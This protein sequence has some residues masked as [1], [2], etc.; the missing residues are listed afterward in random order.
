MKRV[1][2]AEWLQTALKVLSD[3]GVEGLKVERIA[4]R[5][6]ISKSGF[7]WHFQD[8]EDLRNQIIEYWAHEY[9]EVV[10]RNPEFLKGSPRD[11]LKR[12]M[13]MIVDADLTRYDLDMKAWSRTDPK[14]ARRVRQVFRVRFDFSREIFRAMGFRGEELEIRTRMFIGYHAWERLTFDS[15]SKTALKKWIPAKI[16]LLTSK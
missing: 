9:T 13:E 6:G 3:E 4:R 7:Y 5:L 8:R 1:T 12:I 2:K 11:R 14:I 10:S 15:E 16:K